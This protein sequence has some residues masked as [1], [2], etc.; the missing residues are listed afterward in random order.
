MIYAWV[1]I[2]SAHAVRVLERIA[3]YRG[4]PKRVRIDNGAEFVS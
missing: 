1:T 3:A 4:Y 2:P